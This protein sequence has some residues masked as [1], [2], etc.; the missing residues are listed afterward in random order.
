LL[1]HHQQHF[2]Q[3][4]S[5]LTLL[6]FTHLHTTRS[7]G[8]LKIENDQHTRGSSSSSRKILILARKNKERGGWV[9]GVWCECESMKKIS[10]KKGFFHDGKQ[11]QHQ[12]HKSSSS[13]GKSQRREIGV[14]RGLRKSIIHRRH[15]HCDNAFEKK[16]RKKK[17]KK[18]TFA[19]RRWRFSVCGC[20]HAGESMDI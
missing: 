9:S 19:Q 4:D 15:S 14:E 3:P 1:S 16:A 5:H 12:Q 6:L 18:K 10:R 8:S 11:H 2:L 20:N 13:N 7:I 17:K